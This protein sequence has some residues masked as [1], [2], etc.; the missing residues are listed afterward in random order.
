MSLGHMSDEILYC[1]YIY[2]CFTVRGYH[3]C[4]H[5][6]S[7]IIRLLFH[8]LSTHDYTINALGTSSSYIII[9]K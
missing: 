6:F 3:V 7:D 5:T 8:V 9:Y 4:F 1:Y 2:I